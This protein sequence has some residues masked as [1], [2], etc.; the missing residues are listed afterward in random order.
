MHDDTT[1]AV[2]ELLGEHDLASV[3]EF[4]AAMREAME[5]VSSSCMVDLSRVEFCDSSIVH[6]LINWSKEA[7]VSEGEALAIV[8]GGETSAISRILA[9]VGLLDRLP[10]FATPQAARLALL[11]GRRPR[12]ERPLGWLTDRELREARETAMRAASE[13]GD[14]D[15]QDAAVHRLSDIVREQQHRRGDP[16]PEPDG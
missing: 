12:H 1:V 3:G 13:Q 15:R 16:G 4:E 7:Q 2:V 11:D 5:S 9:A 14:Q 10:V 8:V 6:V